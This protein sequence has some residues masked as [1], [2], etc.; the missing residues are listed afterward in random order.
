MMSYEY[1]QFLNEKIIE[2]LPHDKVQV[3]DKYNFRCPICGDSHKSKRK[4]RGWWYKKSA[5]FFCFNCSTGM[6]GIRFL[7]A[8]SGANYDEIKKEFL[9]LF[10]KTH[11]DMSLSAHYEVP[12]EEPS[13]F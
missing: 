2:Y 12:S 9:K 10:A 4:R 8:V 6:S 13:L 1:I 11:R 5:S 7:E 3:G